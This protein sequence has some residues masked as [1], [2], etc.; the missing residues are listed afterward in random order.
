[1]RECLP[2]CSFQVEVEQLKARCEKLEKER[3]AFKFN[4]DQL[5]AK[6]RL[7]GEL[8][9]DILLSTSL[10]FIM[11]QV[12]E[13]SVD[14]ADEQTTAN[15]ASEILETEQ[16][17]RRRLE[18]EVKELTV[19]LKN[20]SLYDDEFLSF[21]VIFS[22]RALVAAEDIRPDCARL[23]RNATA[24]RAARDGSGRRRG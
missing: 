6:V 13:M 21:F 15:Q 20:D 1:M 2:Q 3:N 11:F 18:K 9:I 12:S 23:V 17:E 14:L 10:I 16:A 4:S 24:E 22:A 19:R 7:D 8:F 5:E